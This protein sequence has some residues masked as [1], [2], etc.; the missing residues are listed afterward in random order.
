VDAARAAIEEW[1]SLRPFFLGELHLL[2]PLTVSSHDWCAFQF[3][4]QDMNAGFA[5]FLRRHDSPFAAMEASLHG[6]DPADDYD[7]SLSPGYREEPSCRMRG[8]DLAGLGVRIDEAP[9]SL[10]VRY[11]RAE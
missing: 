6:I 9:G 8:R 3:H 10:L 11:C 1:R 5:V 2:V 7:V 4:R